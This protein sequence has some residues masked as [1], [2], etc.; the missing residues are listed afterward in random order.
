MK[1][2]TAYRANRPVAK[3]AKQDRPNEAAIAAAYLLLIA[4]L[5]IGQLLLLI[6]P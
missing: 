4:G 6:S 3:A 2:H 1:Q 5:L